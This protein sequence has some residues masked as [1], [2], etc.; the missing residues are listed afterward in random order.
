MVTIKATELPV[1]GIVASGTVEGSQL[2]L[3]GGDSGAKVD[4][5]LA[6]ADEATY[7]TQVAAL[8]GQAHAINEARALADQLAHLNDL[9]KKMIAGSADAET[10][11]A[12]FPPIEQRYRTITQMMSAA[13]VRQQSIHGDV[14]ASVAR[15][16]IAVAINQA[17][18]DAEQ[19]YI[20]LQ[21]ADRDI[22]SKVRA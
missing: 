5:N 14:Q 18:I 4:L 2:H 20:S 19:L 3:S 8:T 22:G 12:K 7:R 11:L 10:Q 9:T 15:G 17:S 16:Q 21:S 6:R 1:G 13:L